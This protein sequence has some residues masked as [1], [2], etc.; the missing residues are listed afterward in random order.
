MKNPTSVSKHGTGGV[1][2]KSIIKTEQLEC[3]FSPSAAK[4]NAINKYK[5]CIKFYKRS[6]STS[7][8]KCMTFRIR[9]KNI[10]ST[11]MTWQVVE[12]TIT[13]DLLCQ[14]LLQRSEFESRAPRH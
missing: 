7:S 5:Y 4:F 6:M 1:C 14:R 2:K 13:R 12:N 11:Q 10:K 9:L 8:R 3:Y